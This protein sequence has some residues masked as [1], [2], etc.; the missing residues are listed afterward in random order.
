MS[1]LFLFTMCYGQHKNVLN[2]LPLTVFSTLQNGVAYSLCFESI[3]EGRVSS[4]A[5][6]KSL[7]EVGDLVRKGMLVT[8]L[9]TWNPPVTHV[10]LVSV[11]NVNRAPASYNRIVVVI[12]ILQA[13]KIV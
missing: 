8:D 11:G 4:L 5:G 3:S 1:P 2:V 10:R 12:E 13:M 9:Q 7:Q 6:L